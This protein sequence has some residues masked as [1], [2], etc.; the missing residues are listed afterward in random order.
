MTTHTKIR[1]LLV[2]NHHDAKRTR[3]FCITTAPHIVFTIVPNRAACWQVLAEDEEAPF[4]TIVIDDAITDSDGI[5]LLHEIVAAG[6]PAPVIVITERTD[7]ESAVTAMKEGA[8]DYLVKTGAYWE[9]LPRVIDAANARYRLV[10]ENQRLH[11]HLANYAAQLEQSVRQAQL[12]KSRLQAVLEQLPEGVLIVGND[13]GRTVA[14]NHAAERL[15]GHAFV[16]DVPIPEYARHYQIEHL[17][18]ARLPPEAHPV[19]RVLRTGEPLMG[20]Q[21][22]I[23]QPDGNRITVLTNAAPL[24]DDQGILVGSVA[25]FQ[26]ISEIKRLENLKDEVLSIASHELKNPLTIIKG[27]A[28]LLNKSPTVQGDE[29]TRRIAHTVVQQSERMQWLVERLLDLSRLELGTMA[30][31]ISTIHLSQFLTTLVEEQQSTTERHTI[32]CRLPETPLI[33]KGDYMRLGQVLTNLVTNT[34]K[35]SPNEGKIV[36]ALSTCETP[37]ALDTAVC[38]CELRAEGPYVVIAVHDQGIGIEPEQQH[39]L[40]NR[41]YRVKDAVRLASGQGLG[42]YISAEIVRLH[43]G[44]ICVESTP[45]E[46]STFRVILP[47]HPPQDEPVSRTD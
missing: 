43:G 9:H 2:Q 29:R 37:D 28:A 20:E 3:S 4:D 17:E 7:V 35:Y 33:I 34:I 38:S 11:G 32:S 27:Y 1:V 21:L 10:R 42:L 30:L 39:T 44:T 45:G 31:N 13:G 5:T 16:P 24:F 18:G 36:L 22:V 14:A 47:L 12:E 25:V 41:F 46:G 26:D 15:W 8:I 40:F 19:A 23:V 6:Y